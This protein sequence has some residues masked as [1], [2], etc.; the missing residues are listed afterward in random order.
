MKSLAFCLSLLLVAACNP[1][2]KETRAEALGTEVPDM[3]QAP[4]TQPPIED[5][6]N[7]MDYFN[8]CK[9][10]GLV[11][12]YVFLQRDGQWLCIED[13]GDEFDYEGPLE[14]ARSYPA[15][16]DIKNGFLQIED[17][18][19]GGGTVFTQLALFRRPDNSYFMALGGYGV[20]YSAGYAVNGGPPKFYVWQA[21]QFNEITSEVWPAV[22]NSLFFREGEQQENVQTYFT[23]PQ[24]GRAITYHISLPERAKDSVALL[25][26]KIEIEFDSRANRFVVK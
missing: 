16:V 25:K 19:T 26:S 15:I 14:A 3:E 13:M 23:L 17:E 12:S 7:V 2:K 5:P 9:W 10:K 4:P 6:Q 22:D 1:T 8:L 18:G 21:N 11:E 24:V 20:D